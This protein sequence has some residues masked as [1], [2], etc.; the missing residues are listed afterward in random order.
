MEYCLRAFENKEHVFWW[1]S[2]LSNE[3]LVKTLWWLCQSLALF[4]PKLT[5]NVEEQSTTE[6]LI[7]IKLERLVNDELACSNIS[8]DFVQS[9]DEDEASDEIIDEIASLENKIK[10][11]KLR[12]A[13]KKNIATD[14]EINNITS[15][16]SKIIKMP[17][18][19]GTFVELLHKEDFPNFNNAE[20]LMCEQKQKKKSF[21]RMKTKDFIQKKDDRRRFSKKGLQNLVYKIF[22][23]FLK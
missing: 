12:M 23:N 3:L 21:R 18:A 7:H 15:T 1:F 13:A 22:L 16:E 9:C 19:A 4:K 10:E 11:H 14:R 17:D 8:S 20:S 6:S 2:Y 5:F